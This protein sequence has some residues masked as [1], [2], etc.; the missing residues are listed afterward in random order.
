[1]KKLTKLGA[2]LTLVGAAALPFQSVDA[3]WGGGYWDDGY[4][5]GP[6]GHHGRW[7]Y[8]GPW[9]YGGYGYGYPGWG[10]GVPWG[11]GYHP[12]GYYP[13]MVAAPAAP[14]KAKSE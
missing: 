14:A 4:G 6:Y 12:W 5:W 10:Y 9:G 11:Y 1:M 8:G 7:G 2:V 3:F 13:P